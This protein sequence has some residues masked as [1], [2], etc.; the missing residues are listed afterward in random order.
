MNYC[1]H[2]SYTNNLNQY[3]ML[4]VYTTPSQKLHNRSADP[5]ADHTVIITT[6][7]LAQG[8]ATVAGLSSDFSRQCLMKQ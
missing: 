3:Q 6:A 2:M 8:R 1:T 5:T 7:E 4:L